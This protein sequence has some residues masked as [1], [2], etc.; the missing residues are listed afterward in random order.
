MNNESLTI[1]FYNFFN[2]FNLYVEVNKER[3]NEMCEDL[4]QKIEN[5]LDKVLTDSSYTSDQIDNVIIAG[6]SSK[7]PRIKEILT[8][9]FNEDKIKDN[10]NAE[11]VNTIGASLRAEKL[12]KKLPNQ[13][14]KTFE[15]LP[16]SLGVG[17]VSQNE[18]EKKIG[19]IMSF[20]I[21]KILNYQQIQKK[22]DTKQ[23]RMINHFLKS[24]YFME[25]INI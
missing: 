10:L 3:F 17:A 25:I 1:S 5:M 21:K 4:Y 23:L 13:K 22:E 6:G 14:L 9:K 20:L 16:F 18:E 8:N 19:Q 24:K 7:I 11:E 15:F 12:A 2:N